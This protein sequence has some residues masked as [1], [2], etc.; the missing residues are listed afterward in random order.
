MLRLIRVDLKNQYRKSLVRTYRRI[1]QRKK[2][3]ELTGKGLVQ[4]YEKELARIFANKAQAKK[5][6]SLME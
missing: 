3:I 2:I 5:I 4:M 6:V 1:E